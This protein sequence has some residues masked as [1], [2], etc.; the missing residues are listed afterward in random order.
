[1]QKADAN[2][3]PTAERV[4]IRSFD[5]LTK[6]V[7]P[8]NPILPVTEWP[9]TATLPN[10]DAGN[11]FIYAEFS[12]PLDIASVLD[13]SPAGQA[14]S[15]LIGPITVLAIDPSSGAAAPV[16]GRAFIGGRTYAGIDPNV[17]GVLRFERWVDVDVNGK[18]IVGAV[19]LNGDGVPDGK[20]FPGTESVQGF[21]GAS[22]LVADN[23][24]VF[25]VDTDGDLSTHERFPVDRQVRLRATTALRAVNQNQLLR[26]VVAS[27]TV[28]TDDIPPEVATTPPP[29]SIPLTSPSFGD[30]DVDPLTTITVEF[31][32]PVQPASVGS[33]P[34]VKLPIISPAITLVFGPANQ[35]TQV[36]YTCMPLSVYDLSKWTLTTQFGFPGNGPASQACG[37][38]NRVTMSFIPAQVRDLSQPANVNTLGAS[39]DF[40]TGEGPGLVNAPVVPDAILVGRVGAVPSISVIDLNGFGQSTGDPQFDFSYQTFPKGW[41][42]FPNNPNLIQ[43]GP[44]MYPPLFP[45]TCTVDGGSAGAFTLTKDTSLEDLLVRPPLITSVGR[46]RSVSRSTS[47]STTARTRRAAASMAATSARSTAR[48]SSARRSRRARRS[49]RRCPTRLRRRSC[50][51]A[52]TRSRLR[53]TPTRRRCASRPCACS[54]S[55]AARSPR[56]SSLRRRPPRA[57]ALRTCSF[58]ATRCASSTARRRASR[59]NSKMPSSKAP[60]A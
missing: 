39:S 52:R 9:T 1:V 22:K 19:D 11:H 51:V 7:G 17:P 42:N 25:V 50:P 46:W 18:P 4:L 36:P 6:N 60:T 8:Q 5:D 54:P 45:G 16:P 10:G 56:R 23:V 58:R 27:S 49:D 29:N 48:R 59:P 44:T 14:N 31:T 12:Q 24:F 40:T 53:R 33:F 21:P 32:E 26:Q 47:S 38:F 37:T 35:Q 13:P 28:G 20:G 41:S 15:G 57:S 55:S 3:Q 43:Y 30:V 34:T 2:G